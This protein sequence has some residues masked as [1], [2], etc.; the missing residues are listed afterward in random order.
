[1]ANLKFPVALLLIL[2]VSGCMNV[3]YVGQRFEPT[4]NV[5]IFTGEATDEYE[6]I[7]KATLTAPGSYS[8]HEIR[9]R[10]IAVAEKNGADA[11]NIIDSKLEPDGSFTV[12]SAESPGFQPQGRIGVNSQEAVD[13]FGVVE[14]SPSKEVKTYKNIV[15]AYFLRLKS[16]RSAESLM[17]DEQKQLLT[18]E[19]KISEK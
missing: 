11:V 19:K 8:S 12:L 4:D 15:R 17:K 14:S 13:S 2:C 10:L 5:R 7:G 1:M 3:N 16:K 18:E 6:I 9:Q